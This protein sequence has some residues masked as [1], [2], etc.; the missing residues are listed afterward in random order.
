[1]WQVIKDDWRANSKSINIAGFR[2][3][4]VYRFGRWRMSIKSRILR[5]P[6]SFMYKQMEKHV[7]FKYG[8]E[9]PYTVSLG[10]HVTF[11]HQHG[12]VIHGNSII[13]DHCIIR[14]GVTIG[15]RKTEK[16]YDAPSI[17]SYVDIGAG[18]KILGS[19]KVG[20]HA[21]IGANAVVISDIPEFSV[22][23]GVPARI[24]KINPKY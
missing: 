20:N 17:G 9:L 7:R 13:G 11:E 16:Q 19:V 21:V 23:V 2:V 22:A 15:I 5:M 10:N 12:I 14:H 6:F 4:L 24:I 8:I 1:M 18:A 3:L